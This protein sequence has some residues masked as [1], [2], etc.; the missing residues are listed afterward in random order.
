MTYYLETCG[1]KGLKVHGDS[2]ADMMSCP[3]PP[4]HQG[5]KQTMIHTTYPE[6]AQTN[7]LRANCVSHFSG[8]WDKILD[9]KSNLRKERLIW[10]SS[11]RVQ[12]IRA[13]KA[14]WQEFEASWSYCV[15]TGRGREGNSS[16]WI[17][18]S[19]CTVQYP[20]MHTSDACHVRCVLYPQLSQSTAPL[21]GICIDLCLRAILD[22]LKVII[23]I[24]SHTNI[25]ILTGQNHA[26]PQI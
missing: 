10:V 13:Q 7:F 15:Y 14:W 2:I 21:T 20:G 16:R 4:W 25:Y 6:F 9:N 23:N 11:L 19:L 5:S 17:I 8:C 22:S 3:V 18:H 24:D 12:R 1:W 26:K